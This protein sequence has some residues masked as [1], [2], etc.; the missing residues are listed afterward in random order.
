MER[1]G[2]SLMHYG[3]AQKYRISGRLFKKE[4][5]QILGVNFPLEPGLN[6]LA[7]IPHTMKKRDL[8][9]LL[10]ILILIVK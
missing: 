4:I 3:I 2:T 10:R 5:K 7:I 8:K 1:S 6:N 9:Y